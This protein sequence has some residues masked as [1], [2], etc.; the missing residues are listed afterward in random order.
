MNSKETATTLLL[1]TDADCSVLIHTA[2]LLFPGSCNP[3]NP[4]HVPPSELD[5]RSPQEI[6]QFLL[7]RQSGARSQVATL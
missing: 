7:N 1:G 5:R 3:V 4:V 2:S 6:T